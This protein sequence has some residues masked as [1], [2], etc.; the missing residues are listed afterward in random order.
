MATHKH[1]GFEQKVS[2][3]NSKIG[4][5]AAANSNLLDEV[6]V[7]KRNYNSLVEDVN[8]RFKMVHEKIFR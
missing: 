6:A 4:K 5:L 3:L 2:D 8:S 1:E 7:L